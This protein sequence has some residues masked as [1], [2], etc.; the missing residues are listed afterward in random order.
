MQLIDTNFGRTDV[1]D[2][3]DE[4]P[5]GYFVWN[6]GRANFPH[7]GYLPLAQGASDPYHVRLDTLKAIYVGDE[8]LCLYA[9]N[10]AHYI[11]GNM[12]EDKFNEIK[13]EYESED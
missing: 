12:T 6:I 9:M 8:Q 2:V 7:E 4:W 5:L 3:V 13:K 11:H 1:F 10:R